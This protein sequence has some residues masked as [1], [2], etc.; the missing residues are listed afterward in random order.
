M[1]LILSL[2]NQEVA[3]G[4]EKYLKVLIFSQWLPILQAI[5]GALKENDITFRLQCTP[6]TLEEFKVFL[7]Q[8]F[9]FNKILTNVILESKPQHN[10]LAYAFH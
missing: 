5:A 8:D 6:L 3:A 7:L 4:E 9:V 1:R 10:L 2:Q